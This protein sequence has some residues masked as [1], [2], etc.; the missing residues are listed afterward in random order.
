MVMH[1]VVQYS[2]VSMSLN[3]NTNCNAL[4]C[5]VLL[6]V[7]CFAPGLGVGSQPG[8]NHGGDLTLYWT[9]QH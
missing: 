9:G 5:R 4:H 2:G 8:H 3:C 1:S 7:E 6:S